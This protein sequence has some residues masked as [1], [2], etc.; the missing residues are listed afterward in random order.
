MFG[1][2]W[3]G[4]IYIHFGGSSPLTEFCWLQNS[5]CV[6]VLRSPI[7]T[8]LL[9]GTRAAA[10]R[11]TLW[12]RTRN[13]IRELLQRAPPILNW[14]ATTL[15]ISPHYSFSFFITNTV[16]KYATRVLVCFIAIHK[17]QEFLFKV[18]RLF[19]FFRRRCRRLYVDVS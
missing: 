16:M 18:R 19:I 11:Q 13:G 8:A 2:F 9:H 12:H 4:T 6:Q 17:S 3:A 14:V 1:V 15:G 10:V 7:L 5:L